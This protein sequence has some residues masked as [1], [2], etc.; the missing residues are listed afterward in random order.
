MCIRDSD[1]FDKQQPELDE[2]DPFDYE[3]YNSYRGRHREP[4]SLLV[5]LDMHKLCKQQVVRKVLRTRVHLA[6]DEKKRIAEK[7]VAKAEAA[8][9]QQAKVKRRKLMA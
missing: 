3:L 7:A 1:H 9:R 4:V 6:E 8:I 5:L 2:V